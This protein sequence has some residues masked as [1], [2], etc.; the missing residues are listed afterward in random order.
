MGF[1]RTCDI[2]KVKQPRCEEVLDGNCGGLNGLR[3]V[4]SNWIKKNNNKTNKPFL[5]ELLET[6]RSLELC[7]GEVG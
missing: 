1:A 5:V 4:R 3:R 6:L 7:L 2:L